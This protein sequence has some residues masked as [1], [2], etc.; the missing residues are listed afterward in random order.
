ME[1]VKAIKKHTAHHDLF[2]RLHSIAAD[3]RFVEEVAKD[4][5]G[6]RFQVVGKS[7]DSKNFLERPSRLTPQQ[8]N[9]AACGIA[10]QLYVNIRNIFWS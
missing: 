7:Y 3:Q 2:H 1:T 8:I 10:I 9:D 4:W 6:G 5:Y